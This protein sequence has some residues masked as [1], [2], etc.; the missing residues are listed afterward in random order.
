MGLLCVCVLLGRVSG[1]MASQAVS[2]AWDAP[3]SPFRRFE[4]ELSKTALTGYAARDLLPLSLEGALSVGISSHTLAWG[5]AHR[6]G[7]ELAFLRC[8]LWRC[9]WEAC[10][11]FGSGIGHS[12]GPDAAVIS[13]LQVRITSM[14][15]CWVSGCP[16]RSRT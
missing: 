12:S 5:F 11:G 2:V 10:V 3:R 1:S 8:R 16:V 9:C 6:E 14:A 13:V 7:H 4:S 15:S